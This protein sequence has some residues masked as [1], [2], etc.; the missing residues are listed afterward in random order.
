VKI[1]HIFDFFSP[2]G[3][4]TV[5]VIYKLSRALAQRGH[6]QTIYTSDFKLDKAYI[7]SLPE[8]KIILFH[9]VSSLG[10]FYLTPSLI[11]DAREKLRNY[12][13]IHFHCFRSFQNIV[14]HHY[15]KKYGVPFIL[16]DH[17]SL[18]RVAAGENNPKWLLRGLFDCIFGYRIFKNAT[19]IVTENKF[20][21]NELKA[22]SNKNDKITIIP[23]FFPVE[24]YDN[25]PQR[26]QFRLKYNL[27]DKKIIMSL[28]RIHQIKG[29]DFLVESFAE[30]AVSRKDIILVIVGPDDGYK[31]E[32]LKLISQLQLSDRVLFTGFLGGNDKLSA[33][34]DADV[35]VQPSRYE[36]A[37]W[38]PIEAVLC[39]TPAIVSQGSG[40]GED[41]TRMDAGYLVEYGNKIQMTQVLE[42]V[43]NDPVKAK[44]KVARAQEYIRTN[45][46]L[47]KKVEEYEKLYRQCIKSAEDLRRNK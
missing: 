40:S 30:L 18:P 37:A 5:D 19:R 20:G 27:G 42:T 38:A 44:G 6:E 35:M 36:Q 25:L 14:I 24:E 26:G 47:S 4:G 34:V 41:I 31:G 12:D 29:L 1:L 13:V 3:G 33:L 46:S 16:D 32:L 10:A 8:V 21:V 39:G 28:G 2:Y 23:L 11:K 45:L 17:G 15:A 43:L 7:A 22:F 9:C